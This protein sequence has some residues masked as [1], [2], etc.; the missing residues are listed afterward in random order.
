MA[1]ELVVA[2]DRGVVFVDDDGDGAADPFGSDVMTAQVRLTLPRVSTIA[3][4]V[5][6]RGAG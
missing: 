1:N 3:V 2:Q 6:S 5:S 4:R